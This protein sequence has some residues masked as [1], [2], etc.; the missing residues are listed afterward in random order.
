[1][2][3][4]LPAALAALPGFPQLR[5]SRTRLR[6]PRQDDADAVFALFSDP[7]VMRYWSRP[8]MTERTEAEAAIGEMQEAFAERDKINWVIADKSD[9]VIGTC[10]L[11]R[12]D[13]RHRRAELGYAL[14]SDRWGQGLAHE[15]VSAALDWAFRSLA[16]HRIEADIDPRND[17]SRR[18][19]ERLGFISEGLLRE[20]Y[21]V[22]E[23]VSDT[24]IFGLLA[25]DWRNGDR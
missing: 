17:G 23:K 20:R 25:S 7:E 2:S 15:A 24:E 11:F 6:G 3:F 21:F 14:R 22:G 9:A 4:D 19:L 5:G 13:A 12:F 1:M 16:L 10:T 18:I 8:P